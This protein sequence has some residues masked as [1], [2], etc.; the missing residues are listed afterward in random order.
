MA[1]GLG[2]TLR[3][4]AGKRQWALILPAIVV[5]VGCVRQPVM[6][7][8]PAFYTCKAVSGQIMVDGSID[9]AAWQAADVIANFYAYSPK[10][11]IDLSPTEARILWDHESLYVAITCTD[12]D[13]WSFSDQPDSK[14]WQ[15]D[16]GEFFV[17]PDHNSPVHYEFVV[18]PNGTLC[19]MRHLS[20]GSGG[21]QRSKAW[22]SGAQVASV[23]D[24]SDGDAADMD[25][26]YT[27]EIAIPLD[28]F[29]GA[30][31]PADGVTWTFGVFRYDFSKLLDQPLLLM[32]IPESPRNG[33][34]YYE[35]YTELFFRGA[36]G[37][38]E[39]DGGA[40]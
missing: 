34:H 18:A 12:A 3:S 1:K 22:S 16:V 27:I 7:V 39:S 38:D 8:G 5:G 40:E 36:D 21:Y 9:E 24:G 31:L 30:T 17:R 33:F 15:G 35:G 6:D 26:G 10:N 20:R 25:I 11:A 32:S 19:D 29:H 13:V 37:L 4:S 28:A 23:V 2:S 14:I